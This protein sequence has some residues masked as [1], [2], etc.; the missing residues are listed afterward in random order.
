LLAPASNGEMNPVSGERIYLLN[1]LFS[2]YI[3]P[4]E[5]LSTH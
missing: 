2:A 1:S 5:K 4:A 3:G